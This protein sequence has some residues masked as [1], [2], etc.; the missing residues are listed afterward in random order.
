[1]QDAI[2][3]H[4]HIIL[5]STSPIRKEIL[6]KTAL[7]FDCISPDFDEEEAKKTMQDLSLEDRAMELSCGKALSI[8]KQFLQSYVIG[9][10]QICDLNGAV[11]SKSKNFDEAVLQ[12]KKLTGKTH[13]QNNAVVI[14]HAGK[15]IFKSFSK[16]TLH[17]RWLSEAQIASYVKA[18][19]AWGSAGSYKFESLGKHLFT[20]VSGDYHAILG[21]NIQPLLNFFHEEKLITFKN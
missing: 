16:A 14:A 3:Q 2:L 11:I 19:Q 6:S 17:M 9:S 13:H 7:K 10:D 12:L 8:S 5:A 15:I 21:F 4:C 1:M 18:D 20:Q